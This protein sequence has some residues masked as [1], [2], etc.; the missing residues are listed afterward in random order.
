MYN[1]YVQIKNLHIKK[2]PKH[3]SIFLQIKNHQN[4]QC[5]SNHLSF[6]EIYPNSSTKTSICSASPT[7]AG[8]TKPGGP[9]HAMGDISGATAATAGSAAAG[10]SMGVDMELARLTESNSACKASSSSS[11]A[12]T[13]WWLFLFFL[14]KEKFGGLVVLV[15]RFLEIPIKN[16][17]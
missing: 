8:A 10:A 16:M 2:H 12:R 1:V 4:I 17:S 9:L 3:T 7:E 6:A 13:S 11:V 15:D 14:F 5:L